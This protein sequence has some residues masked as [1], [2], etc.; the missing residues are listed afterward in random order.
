M[1]VDTP[2]FVLNSSPWP[3]DKNNNH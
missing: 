2:N 3:S 1:E